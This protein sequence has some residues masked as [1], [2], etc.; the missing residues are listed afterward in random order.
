[1]SSIFALAVLQVEQVLDDR[2][3]VLARAACDACRGAVEAEAH[4]HL[5]A[6]DGGQVV[7]LADR[8]TGR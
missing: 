7:A 4:V 8:R 2:D 1:M 5:H 3:D 6:A